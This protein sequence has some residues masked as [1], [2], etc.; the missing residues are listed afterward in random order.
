VQ[1]HR[2]ILKNSVRLL[3]NTLG[4]EKM[5]DKTLTKLAE[6]EVNQHAQAA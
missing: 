5:T 1:A 3:E 4:E 2:D 6:A